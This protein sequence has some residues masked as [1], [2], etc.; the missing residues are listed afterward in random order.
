MINGNSG[1][2]TTILL[3]L[4]VVCAPRNASGQAEEISV[5]VSARVISSVELL[6]L[7][8]IQLSGADAIDNVVRIDPVTSPNAGKMVAFGTPNS[9]I[10]ISYQQTLE[11]THTQGAET[12]TFTYQVA[13]NRQED[14]GT[15][16]RLDID[17]RDFSF[18]EKGEFFLWIGGTVNISTAT[19][20]N[21]Q[22]EFT[23]EI[24]YI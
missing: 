22:G 23:L 10:R 9:D 8:S 24:D 17:N 16:E 20:G 19:P 7:K 2:F 5:Q 11:L 15:A 1:I 12:L 3:L 4:A 13:G 18:N 6:T 14:Q 21:Y